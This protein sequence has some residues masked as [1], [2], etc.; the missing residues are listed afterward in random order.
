LSETERHP[1]TYFLQD[2]P[3]LR[4]NT[5]SETERHPLTSPS[6][7][8]VGEG[9]S[10]PELLSAGLDVSVWGGVLDAL[11]ASFVAQPLAHALTLA[12]EIAHAHPALEVLVL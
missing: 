12:L 5:L 3:L 4:A 11:P 6:K 7:Y 2:V 9:V 10:A 1:R 8:F